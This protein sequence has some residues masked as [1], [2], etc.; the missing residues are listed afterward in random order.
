MLHKK[1]SKQRNLVP[2]GNAGLLDRA[3][4]QPWHFLR[5]SYQGKLSGEGALRNQ[6]AQQ[7]WECCWSLE[8]QPKGTSGFTEPTISKKSSL[9]TTRDSIL[10]EW[11]ALPQATLCLLCHRLQELASS[12]SSFPTLAISPGIKI[13]QISVASSS[14]VLEHFL[15]CEPRTPAGFYTDAGKETHVHSKMREEQ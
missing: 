5:S 2:N 11:M 8:L 3:A 14:P 10:I 6:T 15:C 13:K 4:S 7:S 12:S 9:P 1:H